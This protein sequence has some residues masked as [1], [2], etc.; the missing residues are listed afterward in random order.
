MIEK[1]NININFASGLDTK[2]D[3]K[4]LD[5]G[6]F[7]SMQNSA[8]IVGKRLT[9]RNG[10]QELTS[11]LAS[12][13]SATFLT[14]LNKN[15]T[16]IGNN[17]Y[18]YN[19]SNA[20][21]LSKGVYAPMELSALSLIKNSINQTQADAAVAPNDLVCVVYT[22]NNGV[23]T[24]Y[25]YAIINGDT[26]QNVVAPTLITPSSGTVTGSPKVFLLGNYFVVVFT[27]NISGAFHLQYIAVSTFNPTTV[28]AAE[29]I[30]TSYIPASTVAW[31]GVVAGGNLY[32]AYNTTSGG[33]SIK[34]TYLS[35]T[36]AAAGGAP[37]TAVVFVGYQ[38]TIMSLCADTTSSSGLVY[39][40]WYYNGTGYTAA[41]SQAPSFTIAMVP[42]ETIASGTI[43]NL[44]SAAQNGTCKLFYE[45]SNVY[46]YDNTIPSNYINSVS[47]TPTGNPVSFHSVFSSGTGTI[48]A[49]SAT[50]LVNGM[51]LVDVTTP[52]NIPANTTFTHSTTTLTLSNNTAGNS[53]SSPGD[54]LNA[55]AVTLSSTTTVVRSVGLASKAFIIDG[56]IY[57][58]SAYE[59]SAAAGAGYQPTYFLIN[60]STS[61]QAAPAIVAKLA[62]SNGGGYLATG[63]PSVTVSDNIAQ[64]VYLYKDLIEA[65]APAGIESI[66]LQ[67]Q[68]VY[69]QTG[70]NLATFT[71]GTQNIGAAEIANGLQLTGGFGWMYDGYLPVEE[72]FFVWVDSVEVSTDASAVTPTG[73][74]TS[75]SNI[76]TAVSSMVGVGIGASITATGVPANQTVTGFTGNTIAFG[77][78]TAT[79]SHSAETITVTGNI[80][81]A[82]QH[83]YQ[84]IYD[85][86]DN[87]GNEYR[88][89]PSIPVEQTTTGTTS[90]NT[91]NIPYLRLTYKIANPIRIRIYRWSTA[92]QVYYEVT[93][94]IQP[95]MNSTTADSVTY[96]DCLADASI[97]GN[98]IIYTTGGVV[99]DVNSSASS[100]ITL[101]DTRAWK[102]K[103]EDGNLLEYSKQIIENVPVEW[104]DLLTYYVA[105]NVGTSQNTG[106][107]AAMAPMDDKLI[108][109]KSVGNVICFINGTGPDNTGENS[110]YPTTPY[111]VVSPVTCNNQK[112][113]VL[114]PSGLMFQASQNSGIWL[115][116]RNLGVTYIG[117]DVEAFNASTVT[118]ATN[119][120]GT[121]EVRFTLD[122]GETLV[123]DYFFGQWDT[124]ETQ[125]Q[126]EKISS[127]VY[128]GLHT[129]LDTYGSVF[130]ESPGVYLDGSNP[131]LMQ[132]TTGPIT[133]AGIAGYQRAIGLVL[134]GTYESPTQLVVTISFNFG[135]FSQ[136]YVITPTN[137]TP[138]YGGDSLYGQTSPYGGPGSLLQWRIPFEMEQ[139]QVFQISAQEVYDASSGQAAGAGFTLSNINCELLIKSGR[140]P[141]AA[142]QTQG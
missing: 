125:G 8:F 142:A 137:G 4:Q 117:K 134:T 79:G 9:K 12:S 74:V 27:T 58:L 13:A 116:D 63:I 110:Q 88:S 52:A 141:I 66:N 20:S 95:L 80:S 69:T 65:Q 97:V 73:T 130:Q 105:P 37:A 118:S 16:G 131:V 120:P 87:Q 21:W 89:A 2:T 22:E 1:K 104:S 83:Y 43:L 100:I 133:L 5:I 124:F 7:L 51:Y 40:N 86:T 23:T 132:F 36:T 90:T 108:L 129:Y 6:K 30:T 54:V 139:C 113:L 15:L 84:V 111:S 3:P 67:A 19:T 39:L 38:A 57:F 50:G 46:T 59:S 44:A 82:Q 10:N 140:R 62:Y 17:V 70:I 25:K 42:I 123:Y 75:G 32:I 94:V 53:A 136:Q 29:D 109:F 103:A 121:T 138:A 127:C 101:F 128:Q 68:A 96:Y 41:M 33:Q 56:V 91:I 60:G 135:A 71:I 106:P 55:Q 64:M 49:S 93:S 48:T 61:T 122:T 45:V 31:D 107:V 35:A 47:V 99:E 24:N 112:S 26:G 34:V 119:V 14:T 81:T 76:V 77:P 114:M 98:S 11:L 72:N 78:L 115:L 85:W 126:V 18:A 28:T 102:V 92:N